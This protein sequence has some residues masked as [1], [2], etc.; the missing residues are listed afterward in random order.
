LTSSISFLGVQSRSSAVTDPLWSSVVL[1]VGNNNGANGSTAFTDQS[2]NAKTITANG[3]AQWSTASAP[4]GMTSSGLYDGTGDYL[5][6]TTAT[7]LNDMTSSTVVKTVEFFINP[8]VLTTGA[9]LYTSSTVLEKGNLYIGWQVLNNGSIR[10]YWFNV[11]SAQKSITSSAGAVSTGAWTHV[12]FDYDGSG[13]LT[14][15]AGGTS[16]GTGT[17]DGVAAASANT[18]ESIGRNQQSAAAFW[19]GYIGP[20]RITNA[21]RYT[22]AFTPPTL[23]FPTS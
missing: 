16:V 5:A 22:G 9:Q 13:N 11:I 4:S 17:F 8:T 23:P 2:N 21:R 6:S 14:I 7:V 18:T 1:L 15:Y 3:N 20:L 12:A 10:A 19:N